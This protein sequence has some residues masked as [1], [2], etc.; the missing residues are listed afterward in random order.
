MRYRPLGE[1]G[2]VVSAVGL[3]C[4]NMG[5][6][7]DRDAT[8]AVVA[9]ALDAGITLFDVADVY[10]RPR[11][12]AEELLGEALAGHRD[13][14]VL[15]TKFGMAMDGVN[16][17]DWGARGSRR[18]IR[19]SVAASLRRLGTD[20][21]DLLQYHRP[22]GI[23]P[24][25]ET[26]AALDEMIRA[27]LVR[28]VGSSNFA[29][30]QAVEAEWTSRS[31]GT[32]R[33]ISAQNHYN[34]LH[35]QVEGELV[36][37]CERYGIGVLP[38]YP[39]ANGLLSGKY[40]RGAPLP[41]GSRLTEE[42]RHHVLDERALERVEMLQQYAGERGRSL[43]DVAIGGLAARPTVSSVIAGATSPEQVQANVASADWEPSS[44][45]LAALDAVLERLDD[46][47]DGG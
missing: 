10:G 15:A 16:G 23:T 32:A 37:A 43:L 31:S 42:P 9:A 2:L 35:R 1:S 20:H 39:L 28:Y 21:I 4:N 3:G 29:A 22:D 46:K 47:D 26:L 45:D 13:E 11:G 33:F 7:L 38:Y 8:K 27:G 18:Y 44:A 19:R 30:W 12:T 41:E 36:P 25:E 14:V 34:L 6:K 24:I 17:P 40:R 5:R